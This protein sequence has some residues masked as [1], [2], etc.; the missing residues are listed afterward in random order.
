M[1]KVKV[2]AFGRF[3]SG[4]VMPNIGVF[5]AWGLLTALFIPT[6]WFPNDQYS[7][8]VEPMIKYILPLL[9]GYN[10]GKLIAGER[11]AIVGSITTVGVI[12][13]T[14][15]P[16]FIG[17]M[18]AGPA[19]GYAIKLFDR[20]TK[21]KIKSGFEMLVNNFS[22][23][24]VGLILAIV[25]FTGVGPIVER[26]N[27]LLGLGVHRLVQGGLLPLTALVV[28]PAKI[29]FLNNAINHGVFGPLGIQQ[30]SEAGK[31]IFFLI[32][33]NPGPGLGVLLAYMMFGK[34]ASKNSASGAA[35]IHFF[36]GIHEIYFPY[37]LMKPM[38]IISV[39]FGGITGI[40]VNVI[41]NT[42][43]VAPPSPGSIFAI[44]ALA[45][46]GGITPILLSVIAATG[47]TFVTSAII[48]KS[49]KEIEQD[50]ETL[51]AILANSKVT[52][53]I[54]KI[55]VACDAGMGSSAM[56]ASVLRKKIEAANLPILVTNCSISNLTEDMELVITHKDLTERAK[57]TVSSPHHLSID[58]FMN[59]SFY[60]GLVEEIK[61][62]FIDLESDSE[63]LR[64]D[65]V[66][67][68]Q[69][70]VS[71]EKAIEQVA[72]HL[73]KL[74]YVGKGYEKYMQQREKVSTTYIGNYVA[75][76]HGTVEGKKEVLNSGIVILQYPNGIDFGDGNIAYFLIGIAGKNDEHVEIISKIADVIEDEEEVL[77]LKSEKNAEKIYKTFNV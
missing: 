33:S 35:M 16:M 10:G 66:L 70:S 43:L 48:L 28:E 7:K 12:C 71:K 19:G 39:I 75:I 42:G 64:K 14:S 54:S 27:E 68:N 69:K 20:Y 76:P 1:V 31:S 65:G 3:L 51:K 2:Q 62:M 34:G 4:M 74:G 15:I 41:L 50:V 53:K 46:R 40:F 11:G 55:I 72:T 77:I 38:L 37:I 57:K 30:V 18:I 8:M 5:I 29:L 21:G 22:A 56:G 13:G 58:N 61:G 67:V 45:P 49:S 32:E 73:E 6:G 24:I 36:G 26:L 44:M 9:I 59:H 47:V 25:F 63:I 52:K 17:A 60:D 23:G